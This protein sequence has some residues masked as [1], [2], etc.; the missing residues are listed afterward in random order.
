MYRTARIGTRYESGSGT[1]H[2]T[3]KESLAACGVLVSV[4]I[5]AWVV[6]KN[7]ACLIGAGCLTIMVAAANHKK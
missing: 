7:P 4:G 2:M 1:D 3:L 5:V 6:E